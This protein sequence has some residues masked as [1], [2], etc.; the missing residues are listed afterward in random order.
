M[1][2]WAVLLEILINILHDWT[3]QTTYLIIDTL[4]EYKK[5]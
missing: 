5:N 3:L 4:D 1:N 2:T